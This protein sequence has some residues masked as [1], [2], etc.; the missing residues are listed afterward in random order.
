MDQLLE[1]AVLFVLAACGAG[2]PPPP[3]PAPPPAPPDPR[4]DM[5]CVARARD[6]KLLDDLPAD[7]DG[8]RV[9]P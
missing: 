9:T 4:V 6:G 7:L 3:L 8:F 1:I 5:A 2:S